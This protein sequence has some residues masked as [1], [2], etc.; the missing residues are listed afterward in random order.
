MAV[1]YYAG[2][3]TGPS[4][5][6]DKFRIAWLAEGGSVNDFSADGTGYRLHIQKTLGGEASYFNLRSAINEV[7][8]EDSGSADD[9]LV[10]GI[11][12]NAST[13]YSGGSYWDRQTGYTFNEA[14]SNKASGCCMSPMSVSA[15]PAYYFFFV[16]NSVHIVV[17]V[18]AGEF[19]MM[20]FGM[21]KKA[22]TYT[23][24][25]YFSASHSSYYHRYIWRIKSAPRYLNA[26]CA[27]SSQPQPQHNHAG[28]M[29]AD[30][31]G[32]AGWR[33]AI[34]HTYFKDIPLFF[35]G[36]VGGNYSAD[37][38][39]LKKSMAYLFASMSPNST[40]NIPVWTPVFITMLRSDGNHSPMGWPE[41]VRFMNVRNYSPG[42]E[43]TYGDE[44]WKVFPSNGV[45]G[46][47][48]ETTYLPYGGFAFLKDDGS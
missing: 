6:I 25:Q 9:S 7:I 1:G 19:Q 46:H 33:R 21:V 5:L 32:T 30:T 31:D 12:I 14:F 29:F 40:N 37:N 34:H 36:A 16:G 26:A 2:T 15:I 22:G 18:T 47:S 39:D 8:F 42:D 38:D 48:S 28:F 11:G 3:S 41:G 44:T 10:T 17:E 23:G 4:D 35:H 24:G 13:A 45:E 43:I 20:S 27:F